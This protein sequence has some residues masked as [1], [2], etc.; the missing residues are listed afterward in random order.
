MLQVRQ[1]LL[2]HFGYKVFPTSC[3]ED[4]KRVAVDHCPDMLLV[5]NGNPEVDFEQVVSQV[6][7]ACPDLIAVVLSP[8]FYAPRGAQG[9]I[10]CFVARDDGPDR[11]ITQIEELFGQRPHRD[12][13]SSRPM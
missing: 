2:E 7:R 1:M 8:Y 13:G 5:D 6:K 12:G 3:A 11:L 10:D 4:A 9:A